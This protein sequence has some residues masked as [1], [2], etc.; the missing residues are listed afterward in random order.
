MISE[1]YLVTVNS[2]YF[3]Q[4]RDPYTLARIKADAEAPEAK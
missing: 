2:S 3:G 1:L 4:E